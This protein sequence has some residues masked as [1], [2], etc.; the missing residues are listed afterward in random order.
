MGEDQHGQTLDLCEVAAELD[1]RTDHRDPGGFG[2][3]P[4]GLIGRAAIRKQMGLDDEG[5]PEVCAK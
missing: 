1:A 4:V 5:A 3:A 2:R